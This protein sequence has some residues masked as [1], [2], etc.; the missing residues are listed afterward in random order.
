MG[1][2]NSDCQS[3]RSL[4]SFRDLKECGR[5]CRPGVPSGATYYCGFRVTQVVSVATIR[6]SSVSQISSQSYRRL[7]EPTRHSISWHH[8]IV[9]ICSQQRQNRS[10]CISR[11]THKLGCTSVS[12]VSN[13]KPCNR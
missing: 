12:K 2:S 7:E 8:C 4:L 9:L 13:L 10:S 1:T 11:T 6:C 5:S 3:C